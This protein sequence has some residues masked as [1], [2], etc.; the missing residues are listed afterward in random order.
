[1][2]VCFLS[3]LKSLRRD[4][5]S[6]TVSVCFVI[7]RQSEPLDSG[8][9]VDDG[10]KIV[11]PLIDDVVSCGEEDVASCPVLLDS[12]VNVSVL[13]PTN[14][15]MGPL[16]SCHV[17]SND[18][19]VCCLVVVVLVSSCILVSSKVVVEPI[20]CDVVSGIDVELVSCHVVSTATV[21]TESEK[22]ECGTEY[23][24]SSKRHAS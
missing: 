20:L 9:D 16:V 14:V 13:V 12:V 1:M 11:E 6:S 2:D 4:S 5:S 17:V 19:V 15:V 18:V 21:V 3:I 24:Y 23:D 10:I 8:D 7:H 22:K